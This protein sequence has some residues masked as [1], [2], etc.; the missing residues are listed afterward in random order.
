MKRTIN[1]IIISSIFVIVAFSYMC[2]EKPKGNKQ[3]PVNGNSQADDSDWKDSPKTTWL[4]KLDSTK[5]ANTKKTLK[6]YYIIFDGSG[7]MKGE[8]IHIAK[9]ALKEFIKSVPKEANVGLAAF[10]TKGNFER[11][12]L[13]SSKE[14][15]IA[16]IDKVVASGHT[17]L[18]ETTAIAYKKLEK[19]ARKQLGYGEYNLVIITDGHATDKDTLNE[20]INIILNDSP[21]TV[22]TIGFKIGKDHILNQKGKIFYTQANNFKELSRSLKK[23]LA[24]SVKF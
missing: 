9:K 5:F 8:K 7:S 13:G 11:A 1:S 14:K 22:H 17:P 6:N 15:I 4:A 19:Q 21:I 18:G 10:D 23:V 16:A 2:S 12:P 3:V 20:S 24:E